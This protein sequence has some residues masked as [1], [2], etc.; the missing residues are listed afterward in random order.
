MERKFKRGD[1]V[2]KTKGSN[3][4][5]T[6]VGFYETKLTPIGYCVESMF[7]QG[8]VQIYPEAALENLDFMICAHCNKQVS[9]NNGLK[10]GCGHC[11]AVFLLHA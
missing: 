10:L 6:V 3:W 7:E 8:S 11:V 2:K 4:H 9:I 1:L 5:G